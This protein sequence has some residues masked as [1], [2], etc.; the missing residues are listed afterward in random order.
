[1]EENLN[2]DDFYESHPLQPRVNKLKYQLTV[3]RRSLNLTGLI[4]INEPDITSLAGFGVMPHLK[5][6]NIT[7]SHI[8][9]LE[10]LPAQPILQQIVADNS[11]LSSFAGLSRHKKLRDVSF[12]GSPLESKPNSRLSCI[13][14]VGPQIAIINKRIVKKSEREEASKYPKITRL[15]LEAGWDLETP[16]PSPEK[17]REILKDEKYRS[18]LD[19]AKSIQSYNFL[20]ER[21][22]LYKSS[23]LHLEEDEQAEQESNEENDKL[24]EEKLNE[25][26]RRTGIRVKQDKHRRKEIL[27][28]ITE[29]ANLV[30]IFEL[31]AEDIK[32]IKKDDSKEAAPKDQPPT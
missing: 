2:A 18:V 19:E 5:V 24:L 3:Q 32:D 9:S 29:L 7:R 30:K 25:I 13:I 23:S 31:C 10:S 20:S 27:E 14:V 11:E 4:S 15:L 21:R 6:L 17:F 16:V 26:L 22:D 12:I 1:M 28:A 8:K